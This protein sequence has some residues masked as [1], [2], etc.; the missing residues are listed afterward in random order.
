MGSLAVD[1]QGPAV[2]VLAPWL[3]VSLLSMTYG[4]HVMLGCVLLFAGKNALV[5]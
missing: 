3:S 5:P 4:T 1:P 2:A